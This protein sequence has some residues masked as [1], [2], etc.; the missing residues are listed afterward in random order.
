MKDKLVDDYIHFLETEHPNHI[1]QFSTRL[2]SL[3][4]SAKSEAVSYYFF[5]SK[6][7]QIIVSENPKSGGL[8]FEC[9]VGSAKFLA[10]ITHLSMKSVTTESGLPHEPTPGRS[11]GW[12]SKITPKLFNTING[13]A[14]QMSGYEYPT[15]LVIASRHPGTDLLFRSIFVEWLLTGEHKIEISTPQDA[16][17]TEDTISEVTELEH[18]SFLRW[19]D[20]WETG[21]RSISSVLL[22]DISAL[23]SVSIFGILHPNPNHSFSPELLP[24]IPFIRLK[25]WPP[26]NNRLYTEWVK[27]ENNELLV[28]PE[29]YPDPERLGYD[30]FL[31]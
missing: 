19:N 10:E 7:D 21:C 27:Y 14:S 16:E 31:Y 6:I 9:H 17:D 5:R 26:Q 25:E 22:F 30:S 8:D 11:S 12:Y 23:D 24:G 28:I 13:K 3:P 4:D 20:D 18:S 15:I 29:P 1:K 2:R